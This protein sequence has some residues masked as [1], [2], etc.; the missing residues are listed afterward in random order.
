MRA[1]T[2]FA[3]LQQIL[4]DFLNQFQDETAGVRV[5]TSNNEFTGQAEPGADVVYIQT[6]NTVGA[7][8]LLEIDTSIDWRD[9]VVSVAGWLLTA[10][11]RLGQVADFQMNDPAF[12][13]RQVMAT[14]FTGVGAYSDV[15]LS[16][17]VGPG[18]APVNAVG[19]VRS[20]A[21]VLY[22]EVT[23]FPAYASVFL[24]CDPGTGALY[25]YNA[26]GTALYFTGVVWGFG[27]TG[28]RP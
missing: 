17:S 24:Y 21:P 19:T 16:T 10:D 22:R 20:Y 2:T 25:L 11:Q 13:V 8:D 6:L 27:T 18:A 23:A 26:T 28:A 4:S 1:I 3:P 5:A 9:R 12:G 14:G 15:V 7:A